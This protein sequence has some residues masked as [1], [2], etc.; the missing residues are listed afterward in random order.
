MND[1]DLQLLPHGSL[2]LFTDAVSYV[3]TYIKK[4]H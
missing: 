3:Y 2:N 1:D 4:Y